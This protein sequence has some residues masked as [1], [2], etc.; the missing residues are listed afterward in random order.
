[1]FNAT[2]TTTK[3]AVATLIAF[4]STYSIICLVYL[5][6]ILNFLYINYLDTRFYYS[7]IVIYA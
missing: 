1:V 7:N 5:S 2:A 4:C 3:D 6:F